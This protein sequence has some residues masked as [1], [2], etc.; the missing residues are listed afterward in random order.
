MTTDEI[1]KLIEDGWSARVHESRRVAALQKKIADGL[2]TYDDAQQLAIEAGNILNDIFRQYLPEALIDGKLYRETAERLIAKPLEKSSKLLQESTKSIQEAL[3]K[4]AGIEFKA[5]VPELNKDWLDGIVTGMCNAESYSAREKTFYAEVTNFLEGHVS[6]FIQKNADFHYKAGLNPTIERIADGKCCSWCSGL[7][8]TYQYKDV[9]NRGNDVYRRHNNCHC[10][11]LYNPGDGSKLRQNVYSK[12]W[13][14]E[15]EKAKIDYN[16][17]KKDLPVRARGF[18]EAKVYGKTWQEA[19]LQEAIKRF[20]PEAVAVS[21]EDGRKIIYKGKE[22]TVAYDPGGD[23]FRI[24]INSDE[25]KR[26]FVDMDGN[27]ILNIEEN[28]RQRGATAEEYLEVTHFRNA[29]NKRG[30]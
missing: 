15:D 6:D 10:R 22:F 7:A 8:G 24:R 11:I 30:H 3:N 1:L 12:R 16:K 21:D 17:M 9:R 20:A 29:D 27:K 4:Q 28:G 25:T 14:H 23:Y 2:A 5:I 26:C 19:S 13:T 18:E